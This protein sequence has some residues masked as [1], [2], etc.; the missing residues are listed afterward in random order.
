MSSSEPRRGDIDGLRAVAII[1]VVMFHAIIPG[2][3]SGYVGVD[4]F[5]VI[6]GYLITRI[7]W[8]EARSGA[9]S[10]GNFYARRA[11][12]LVPAALLMTIVTCLVATIVYPPG[13]R[14]L[15]LRSALSSVAYVS[16]IRFWYMG[17]NYF[18][19]ADQPN[20]FLHTWSLSVEEQFY[21]GWPL[22][23]LLMWRWSRRGALSPVAVMAAL[24]VISFIGCIIESQRS[25]PGAF[26][27][28]PFRGW[29]FAAGA[30]VGL[31][32]AP[33]PRLALILGWVGAIAIVAAITLLPP[34]TVY[35]GFVALFPVVA[36]AS[37]LA[38]GRSPNPVS[39]ALAAGPAQSIGK[40]SYSWYLWHW[41]VLIIGRDL[42]PQLTEH[43][44][45]RLALALFALALAAATYRFVEQPLRHRPALVRSPRNSLLLAA[46]ATIACAALLGALWQ[47]ATAQL[48]IE[49]YRTIG[50]AKNDGP[51]Q[52]ECME[53]WRNDRIDTCS[54]GHGSQTVVLYGDSHAGMWLT[55]LRRVAEG[56]GM[57]L[58]T[59]LKGACPTSDVPVYDPR[60]SRFDTSCP[61]WRKAAFVALR[62]IKPSLIFVTSSQG[63][64]RSPGSHSR[65]G[66]ATNSDAEWRDGYRR[67]LTQFPDVPIV[68]IHD[69]PRFPAAVPRCLARAVHNG[70][71]DCSVARAKAIDAKII[72]AEQ[73]AAVGLPNV[74]FLDFTDVF[75]GPT[76]CPAADGL[77]PRYRDNNHVTATF[78]LNLSDRFDAEFA[79]LQPVASRAAPVQLGRGPR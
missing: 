37:L 60:L 33:G 3:G 52:V 63:Y 62:S 65:D 27:M 43:T 22:L 79:R 44:T 49:P 76:R 7:I 10:F 39:R 75:C 30:I 69:A 73:E 47:G 36:T 15:A 28:L 19:E 24:F 29:E 64:V 8:N 25:L 55:T 74:R 1:P 45:A 26:F 54:F 68:V 23:L 18:N 32:R 67:T 78:A 4:I 56:R 57:R 61:K 66:Y 16:N 5:F 34:S 51:P 12:R 2:F 42:F 38:A 11:R 48:R 31:V 46:A 58:V 6:S 14:E 13:E 59:M 9:F 70:G 53:N 35:P 40:F 20:L 72:R 41:P 21:L 17:L 71:G 77:R 50:L